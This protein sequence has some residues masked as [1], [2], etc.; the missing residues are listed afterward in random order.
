MTE[1]IHGAVAHFDIAGDEVA[2]LG[3][4]YSSLFNWKID[5]KGPGYALIETPDGGPNGAIVEAEQS[6]LTLGIAVQNLTAMLDKV[7]ATGGKIVMPVT[8][9]GWVK[10]AQI[11]DPAGTVVTLIEL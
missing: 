8:D 5:S 6:G 7:E 4:F 3:R 9:N 1:Y 11:A 2:T 10:K